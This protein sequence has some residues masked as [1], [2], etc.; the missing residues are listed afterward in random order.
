METLKA[1]INNVAE[2]AVS[3]RMTSRMASTSAAIGLN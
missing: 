3:F 2:G 1:L